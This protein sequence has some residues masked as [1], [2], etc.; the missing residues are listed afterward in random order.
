MTKQTYID[1]EEFG[2]NLAFKKG[3]RSISKDM[4]E[5]KSK[6]E[7]NSSVEPRSSNL[8]EILGNLVKP[9]PIIVLPHSEPLSKD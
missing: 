2:L 8:P 1:P 3:A 9:S 4:R 5:G 7:R 6:I